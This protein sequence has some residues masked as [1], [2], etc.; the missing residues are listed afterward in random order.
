[1]RKEYIN[2]EYGK[3]GKPAWSFVHGS[4]IYKKKYKKNCY[5]K[6]RLVQ[7]ISISNGVHYNTKCIYG[8]NLPVMWLLEL[9]Y[10]IRIFSI[11][12]DFHSRYITMFI[13]L[14]TYH[15]ENNFQN[16]YNF[17]D[18]NNDKILQCSD[19]NILNYGDGGYCIY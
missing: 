9:Y 14:I 12:L 18:S 5:A 2:S 13:P 8:E 17:M 15:I 10:K 16:F 4:Y 1:M 7:I 19:S 6:I 3:I 11:M